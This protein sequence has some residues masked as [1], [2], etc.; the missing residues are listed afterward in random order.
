L[1]APGRELAVPGR[2][3]RAVPRLDASVPPSRREAHARG[4]AATRPPSG[5]TRPGRVRSCI[6]TREIVASVI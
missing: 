1:P 6:R 3:G 2:A 5:R 4:E